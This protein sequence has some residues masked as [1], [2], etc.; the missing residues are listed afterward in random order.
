M[1]RM[2]REGHAPLQ[3]VPISATF[4]LRVVRGKGLF[5]ASPTEVLRRT[6]EGK[7]VILEPEA[8][9]QECEKCGRVM[10]K[11]HG[12]YGSF[13]GC[14]GYP[15]CNNVIPLRKKE[16]GKT[17]EQETKEKCEKC[18]APMLIKTGRYGR[19][20]A[21]SNYPKC[22]F[23]KPLAI[24]I[25]CLREGCGGDLVERRTKQGRIFYS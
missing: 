24:G 18:G 14:S 1:T 10:L 2:G 5:S 4:G 15:E 11:K 9:D 17:E 23:V 22:K 21:C 25:K 12:R 13:L 19:F 7:I 3:S 8:T 6:E 16:P 20:L